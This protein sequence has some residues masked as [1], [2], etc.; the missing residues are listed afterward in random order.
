MRVGVRHSDS[1]HGLADA[2]TCL[3]D[4]LDL[5]LKLEEVVLAQLNL[6]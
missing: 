5:P 1:D 6:F 3:E 4:I 2:V